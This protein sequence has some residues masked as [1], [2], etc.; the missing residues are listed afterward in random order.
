MPDLIPAR[1]ATTL[2]VLITLLSSLAASAQEPDAL[3]RFQIELVVFEHLAQP[4]TTEAPPVELPEPPL[5]QTEGIVPAPGPAAQTGPVFFRLAPELAMNNIAASLQR[6][7]EYR[8]L[9]HDA[10]IQDG[11]EGDLARPVDA[12]LFEQMPSRARS[13]RRARSSSGEV[14]TGTV[15][16]VRGRYLHLDI[17]LNLGNRAGRQLRERRRVRLGEMHY[18]DAPGLGV[19][20]TVTRI[21]DP[22]GGTAPE[23]GA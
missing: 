23:S 16:F 12:E 22:A 3:P 20:A 18:F 6:R 19:I 1:V 2:T 17:D 14:V 4:P 21:E 9:I 15:T 13:A 11:Y 10:W 7:Q 8:V 5:L